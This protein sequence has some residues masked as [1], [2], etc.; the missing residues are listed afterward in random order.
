MAYSKA[1]PREI[2]GTSYTQWQEVE[3]TNEEERKQEQKARM[4]N[5]F[6]LRQCLATQETY[7]E[8]KN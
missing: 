4:E 8:M 3:L 1:F 2:A 7:S 5:I 6:L